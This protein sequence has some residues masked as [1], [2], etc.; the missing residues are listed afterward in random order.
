MPKSLLD[1]AGTGYAPDAA[2]AG[3]PSLRWRRPDKK[4]KTGLESLESRFGVKRVPRSQYS[5]GVLETSDAKRSGEDVVRRSIEALRAARE[6]G[7]ELPKE[8]YD[9]QHLAAM[10]MQ[11]GRSDFGAGHGFGHNKKAT[12][13]ANILTE[14]FGPEAGVFVGSVYD[15]SEVARRTKKPF[16]M[17]WNGV[18]VTR[19]ADGSILAS[20]K[21][22]AERF[23][24]F[25]EAA[26]RP[27]NAPLRDFVNKY[28]T[29]TEYTSPLLPAVKQDMQND[30][31][32]R[33]NKVWSETNKKLSKSPLRQLQH[34]FLGGADSRFG[35]PAE[36]DPEYQRS[37]IKPPDFEKLVKDLRPKYKAGGAIENTTHDRKIL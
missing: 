3:L 25:Y 9:P 34:T 4:S 31:K 24:M 10:L 11:E 16:A 27:E 32:M 28:L 23:P 19:N 6:L 20:G 7:Y 2:S 5:P 18:G 8:I 26:G 21:N 33:Q 36:Y 13:L 1:D 29:G 17:V 15:K 35:V 37:Q 30:Y 14:R 12:E 22:Y